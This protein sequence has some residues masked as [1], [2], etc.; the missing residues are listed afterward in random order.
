M[1]STLIENKEEKEIKYP[2]LMTAI[3]D[4]AGKIVVLF[5]SKNFGTVVYSEREL[6]P[7]GYYTETWAT[8]RSFEPFDGTIELS[9]Q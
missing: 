2:C 9:N 5:T 1:K 7:I 8:S 3:N 4:E 6:Y